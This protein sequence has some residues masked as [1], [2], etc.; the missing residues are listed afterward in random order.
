MAKKRKAK[1]SRK[2]ARIKKISWGKAVAGLSLLALILL[3]PYLIYL[4]HLV[5]FRFQ[6]RYL[7]DSVTGLCATAGTLSGAQIKL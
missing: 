4:N 7:G 3:I 1:S 2:K 6:G 5:N